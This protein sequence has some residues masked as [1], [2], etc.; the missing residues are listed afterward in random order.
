MTQKSP[1][2]TLDDWIDKETFC[3]LLAIN[4]R[5]ADRWTRQRQGPKRIR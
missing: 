2:P 4:P 1:K 5:T 3:K